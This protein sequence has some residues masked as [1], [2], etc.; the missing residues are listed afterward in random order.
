MSRLQ[1]LYNKIETFEQIKAKL[2]FWKLTSKKIV[3]T[4]G[5]FDILHKGHVTYLAKAADLG[6]VLIVGLNS[7]RSVK[8]LKG[9]GRPIN[10]QNARCEVLAALGFV[11]AVIVFDQPTPYELIKLLQPDVLVKGGDWKV[12]EIV[13]YDI[14]KAN[15]G[16][17]TNIEF[18]QGFSTTSIERKL[19][20]K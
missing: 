20:G 2:N 10:E 17:V 3:F 19:Q 14:L 18:V 9:S 7:D 6:N 1:A 15:G 11:D 5:C 4:N 13:G 8:E 12:E 16:L